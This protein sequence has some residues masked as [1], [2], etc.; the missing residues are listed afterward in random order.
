M[1][2]SV[3]SLHP[4]TSLPARLLASLACPSRGLC[5][6][7]GRP[8]AAVVRARRTRQPAPAAGERRAK[9]G[10]RPCTRLLP[11]LARVLLCGVRFAARASVRSTLAPRSA[12][13]GRVACG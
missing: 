6:R 8:S 12:G 13:D 7:R 10:E 9:P 4:A 3:E 5:G 11:A 2:V 1:A